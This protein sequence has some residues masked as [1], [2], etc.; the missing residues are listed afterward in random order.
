MPWL[1]IYNLLRV[2]FGCVLETSGGSSIGRTRIYSAEERVDFKQ[3]N[4]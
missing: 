1:L 2:T 4:Y 3:K